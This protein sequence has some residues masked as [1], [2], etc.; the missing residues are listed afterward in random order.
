MST[1]STNPLVRLGILP[2]Q[3]L[4]ELEGHK[5]IPEGTAS[6]HGSDPSPPDREAL[7]EEIEATLTD[8]AAVGPET[9]LDMPEPTATTRVGGMDVPLAAEESTLYI[10]ARMPVA[11]EVLESELDDLDICEVLYQGETWTMV[12]PKEGSV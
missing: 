10:G 8:P 1:N 6:R 9:L 5:A 2:Q 7:A 4:A 12:K 3:T 11:I